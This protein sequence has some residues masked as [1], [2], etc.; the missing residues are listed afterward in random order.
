M[1]VNSLIVADSQHLSMKTAVFLAALA[2]LLSRPAGAGAEDQDPPAPVSQLEI[3][4]NGPNEL[5]LTWT[6]VQVD[7]E[8]DAETVG[9]YTVYGFPLPPSNPWTSLGQTS[10]TS[11]ATALAGPNEFYLVTATDVAGNQGPPWQVPPQGLPETFAVVLAFHN[12]EAILSWTQPP[13]ISPTGYIVYL[14]TGAASYQ[15]SKQLGGTATSAG[16]LTLPPGQY[17]FQVVALV[18]G[19]PAARSNIVLGE[20][21]IDQ[22]PPGPVAWL[23][24]SKSGPNAV[25][26]WTAVTVDLEGN[27]EVVTSYDVWSFPR[28]MSPWTLRDNTTGLASTRPLAGPDEFYL[29]MPRDERGNA[30]PPYQLPPQ[31]VL[32]TF[33][34]IALPNN[35][36]AEVR[37]VPPSGV[38]P[39]K[40]VVYWGTG[41]ATYQQF[42]VVGSGETSTRAYPLEPG[43]RYFF[44]ALAIQGTWVAAQS[45][46]ASGELQPGISCIVEVD[47]D[48]DVPCTEDTCVEG[49]CYGIPRNAAASDGLFCTG[50]EVCDPAQV[51]GIAQT[52]APCAGGTCN[53]PLDSC[54]TTPTDGAVFESYYLPDSR[55][56][57]S[58]DT[59]W[60]NATN[61]GSTVWARDTHA[62]G[63]VGD[64]D[65]FT[66]K[67]RLLLPEGVTVSPGESFT[68]P[69]DTVAPSN[70]GTYNTEWQMVRLDPGGAAAAASAVPGATATGRPPLPLSMSSSLLNG[71]TDDW[72]ARPGGTPEPSRREADS[73]IRE[74]SAPQRAA[75]RFM[76]EFGSSNP[77]AANEGGQAIGASAGDTFFGEAAG[78]NVQV[79]NCNGLAE[80]Q[81]WSPDPMEI[82][83][84]A[85]WIYLGGDNML[86]GVVGGTNPN[87]PKLAIATDDDD[88]NRPVPSLT[89]YDQYISVGGYETWKI[90]FNATA[91]GV[92]GDYEITVS[93]GT[94][95]TC[96]Y[97]LPV[98]VLPDT[99]H[100]DMY[101][102][103]VPQ[104][105]YEGVVPRG[106]RYILSI[107][108]RNL[109]DADVFP[110]AEGLDQILVY[111]IEASRDAQIS[112]QLV[113]LPTATPGT[114]FDLIVRDPFEQETHLPMLIGEG[115]WEPEG[116]G[117]ALGGG[118]AAAQSGSAA[119]D[120]DD[121]DDP[122]VRILSLPQTGG[123]GRLKS[124]PL[125][126]RRIDLKVQEAHMPAGSEGMT[127]PELPPIYFQDVVA[128]DP[129]SLRNSLT[130]RADSG[131]FGDDGDGIEWGAIGTEVDFSISYSFVYR[132]LIH[133]DARL[134]SMAFDVETGEFA[135]FI[136]GP[137]GTQRLLGGISMAVI[138]AADMTLY[139]GCTYSTVFGWSCHAGLCW[140][141][142]SAIDVIGQGYYVA[143]KGCWFDEEWEGESDSGQ[144]HTFTTPGD[145]STVTPC[146]TDENGVCV[147]EVEVTGCCE[148]SLDLTTEGLLLHSG[149]Q[150]VI[151]PFQ[152]TNGYFPNPEPP[153]TSYGVATVKSL[154]AGGGTCC[155]DGLVN[156]NERCD[157][158]G[159]PVNL[160][161]G[162]V[163]L[164]NKACGYCSDGAV[165][166]PWEQ[167]DDGNTNNADACPN[168]CYLPN[169]DYDEVWIEWKSV[170][171]PDLVKVPWWG[172]LQYDYG[173]GDNW[174][175]PIPVTGNTSAKI[176]Q[177]GLFSV[178][179]GRSI[180]LGTDV[181]SMA[182][183]KGFEDANDSGNRECNDLFRYFGQN[184][185]EP[186][187]V[188]QPVFDGSVNVANLEVERLGSN[189]VRINFK[190]SARHGCIVGPDFV[191]AEIDYCVSV[192][193]R[194]VIQEGG[195]LG[196][197][198][199]KLT[200]RHDGFPWHNL[201]IGPDPDNLHTAYQ[202]DVCDNRGTLLSLTG[203]CDDRE[204]PDDPYGTW[205]EVPG[206]GG[207]SGAGGN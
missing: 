33:P 1:G 46:I 126:E 96:H 197:V 121:S 45:T 118:G 18:G 6:P 98:R 105:R 97:K 88:P 62:L 172:I 164:C 188:E 7:L 163:A 112:A 187:C 49:W 152:W 67:V 130:Q 66:T 198:E 44:Q 56:N 95:D 115:I 9:H 90:I 108:G 178:D 123:R 127:P 80:L 205:R 140:S 168:T 167:C 11:F 120:G 31:G 135:P 150:P 69:V 103:G 191:A 5:V 29:V 151:I 175:L 132:W 10:G 128:L 195:Q 55:R 169:L 63:A 79:V 25:L 170:L 91:A 23:G 94:N 165:N 206:M 38:T 75:A 134:F 60:F 101:T 131:E 8:G 183:S 30:G 64:S 74:F 48:D 184:Q 82:P 102:P 42:T 26:S 201:L 73:E 114:E 158:P 153:T 142:V 144:S 52:A 24:L 99:P 92:M 119:P 161:G 83:K 27:P 116:G 81:I 111:D 181:T 125:T 41:A 35:T 190:G 185:I 21:G 65:P 154:P 138:F 194:Q 70:A 15:F 86:G 177:A 207:N 59:V 22:I 78:E 124:L 104:Q 203:D 61:V 20:V 147:T 106:S 89:I 145:C 43:T 4:K 173:L 53:E 51:G 37:W 47:C 58:A 2:V 148:E 186:E 204:I 100:V 192:E 85:W 189:H 76:R 16:T 202:Y 174:P 166:L 113:V 68:F 160:P 32:P 72:F 87:V 12:N 50:A 136:Q 39:D 40:Y 139:G 159:S 36:E 71:E 143:R 109:L 84:G 13:G 171:R 17:Y 162:G 54:G 19:A 122:M 182:P 146:V 57:G 77:P 193:L 149:G 176:K 117:D 14:G 129:K 28:K 141:V 3:G 34:L 110:S 180:L 157:P 133:F 137:P 196:P 93:E 107:S 199:Y 156:Q 155:G 179:P 200:G